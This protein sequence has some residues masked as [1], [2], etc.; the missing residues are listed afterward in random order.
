MIATR[1]AR[2]ARLLWANTHAVLDVA[3]SFVT[4]YMGIIAAIREPWRCMVV[5]ALCSVS[6][7]CCAPPSFISTRQPDL[8]RYHRRIVYTITVILV[9]L[10]ALLGLAFSGASPFS[11]MYGVRGS[12]IATHSS[13]ERAEV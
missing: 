3:R 6:F 4:A 5:L 13:E 11:V 8:A 9:S 7:V 10:S 1:S 12:V 2:D